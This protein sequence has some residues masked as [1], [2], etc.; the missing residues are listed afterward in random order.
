MYKSLCCTSLNTAVP[1][2]ASERGLA[3][4]TS[5]AH[6]PPEWRRLQCSSEERRDPL[7]VLHMFALLGRSA[8]PTSV[9][10][11]RSGLRK[12]LYARCA[13]LQAGPH[14]HLS[15]LLLLILRLCFAPLHVASSAS[16]R[17]ASAWRRLLC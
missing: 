2:E 1:G 7:A 4:R 8:L 16:S 5:I 12:P 17:L 11:F 6:V 10:G 9:R 3:W 14:A 13:A 15:V